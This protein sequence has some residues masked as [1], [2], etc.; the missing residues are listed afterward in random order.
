MRSLRVELQ[1]A[2]QAAVVP[3]SREPRSWEQPGAGSSQELGA[4]RSWALE[5]ASHINIVQLVAPGH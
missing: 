1:I 3:G 2:G 4:A 5:L